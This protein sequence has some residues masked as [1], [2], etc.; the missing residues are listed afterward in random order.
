VTVSIFG[1]LLGGVGLFLLGMRLMTDGLKL[2]AGEALRRILERSTNTPLRGVFSGALIT[3]LVQSSSAVTVATIG[4]VNAGLMGLKPAIR[5][6]YG[7][8][9]GTTAT[10]WLVAL[11]GLSIS[12]K[13]FALPLVGAGML[14]RLTGGEGRRGA[15]GD[16]LVGFGIFLLAIE[17]LHSSFAGLG[18][19][20]DLQAVA[21]AGIAGTVVLVGVG[22][23]LTVLMQSSSAALTVVLTAAGGGVVPVDAAAAMVIGANVG[24]TSTAAIAVIDATPNAKRVAAAHVAFNLITATVAVALL[25]LWLSLLVSLRAWLDMAGDVPAV[26]ALFHSTFNVIGLALMWPITGRLVT[27]LEHRFRTDEEDEAQPHYL[28]ANV[29]ATPVL[30]VDALARELERVAAVATR[31][32]KSAISSELGP[33]PR[34]MADKAV[35]DRLIEAIG[36]FTNVVQRSNLPEDLAAKLPV[37]FRVSGYY[38]IIAELAL[39]V[40][41]RRGEPSPI[42][43]EEVAAALARY[44]GATVALIESA[45]APREDYRA[46]EVARSMA[47]LE[48]EYQELKSTLLHAGATGTLATRRLVDTLEMISDIRRIARQAERAARH[49]ASLE[50][51]AADGESEPIDKPAGTEAA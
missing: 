23:L 9:V 19:A 16:A 21:H 34:L 39:D 37:V 25:P 35:L 29:V 49:L 30:A 41:S 17:V 42:S 7:S 5:V 12:V 3:S 40:A 4:F 38:S 22:A 45:A 33:G 20:I 44:R 46:D 11:V 10:A 28:D 13:A 6:V 24:T 18:R 15:T 2:A 31:M 36:T 32:A 26:L 48:V 8:N 1:A 51:A 27:F 47:E 43:D 14:L 50:D